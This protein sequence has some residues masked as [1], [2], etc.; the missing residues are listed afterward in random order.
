MEFCVVI[1]HLLVYRTVSYRETVNKYHAVIARQRELWKL[2][3]HEELFGRKATSAKT[4]FQSN[5][6]QSVFLKQQVYRVS[7]TF[8]QKSTRPSLRF[9]AGPH[10]TLM[11]CLS[12]P[13][14]RRP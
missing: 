11:S 4:E 12:V 2:T 14:K 7:D 5:I 13:I 9:L 3:P 6:S 1:S 8:F 10:V